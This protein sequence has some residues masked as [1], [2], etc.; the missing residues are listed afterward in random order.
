MGKLAFVLPN[1]ATLTRDELIFYANLGEKLGYDTIWVPE[2][3]GND[4]FTLMAT[5]LENTSNIKAASGIIS[6]FSRSAASI[7]QSIATI[8]TFSGGRAILGLGP[9]TNIVNENWHGMKHERALRRTREY[10]EIIRMVLSG[11]RVNHEGELIKLRNMKFQSKPIRRNIPVYLASLGPKNLKLTGELADGWLPFLCP[12]GHIV[13]LGEFIKDSA[14]KAGRSM[15]DITVC[16]YVPALLSARDPGEADFKIKEFISFY[17]GAMGPHYYDLVSSYG[18]G[19]D[20]VN[21]REAWNNKDL[22]KCTNSVSNEL[23]ELVA[24]RGN[25]ESAEAK[26]DSY[27]NVSDCPILMFPFKSTKDQIVE[28][29]ETLAPGG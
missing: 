2:T 3:W 18:F 8:D 11:E 25:A 6:T 17:V 5:I 14:V 16:P 13:K 22:E 10:V 26:L 1:W 4:A 23:L 27:R 12:E 15:E 20:A 21:I 19:E 9:S 28:T 29:L 24:V 7:A